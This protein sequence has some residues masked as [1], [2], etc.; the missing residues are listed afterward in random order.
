MDLGS[1]DW[2][3][4]SPPGISAPHPSAGALDVCSRYMGAGNQNPGLLLTL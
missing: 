2:L 1:L 4:I 3:T